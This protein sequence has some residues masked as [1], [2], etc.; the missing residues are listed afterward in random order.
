MAKWT[1]RAVNL[2]CNIETSPSKGNEASRMKANDAKANR[3]KL[4][5][6][7]DDQNTDESEVVEYRIG[8]HMPQKVMQV[9]GMGSGWT[10]KICRLMTSTKAKLENQE[11]K[12]SV[13][14][15]WEALI[16]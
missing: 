4:K 16:A 2:V 1:G 3:N 8:R 11:C 7:K 15:K 10:C 14:K 6:Q 12:G 5:Q 13:A 9:P